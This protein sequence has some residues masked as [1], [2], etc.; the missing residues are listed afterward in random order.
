MD[1]EKK[2]FGNGSGNFDDADFIL[3][4]NQWINMENCRIGS[5][6]NGVIGTVESI[7]KILL[8]SDPEPSITNVEIGSVEDEENRRIIYFLKDLYGPW[9][10]IVVYDLS[11]DIFL[12]VLYTFQVT[13]GLNFNKN[14]LI[15]SARVI[16]GLLYWTDNLNQPRRINIDAGINMN[17]PATIPN[18]EPYTNPLTQE[19]I[20]VIRRPPYYPPSI[21]KDTDVDYVNNFIADSATQ[22]AVRYRY[23]D[24]E[25][26]VIGP[27]SVLAP[28]NDSEDDSNFINITIPT[29]EIIDQ[30]V[31]EAELIVK[32]GNEAMAF[33]IHTWDRDDIDAHN[34]GTALEFDF[35]NDI[36]GSAL[37]QPTVAKPFDSVP[38]L[39]KTLETANNR[40]FLGNNL[41]G[42]NTPAITSLVIGAASV[43]D[44]G[45]YDAVWGIYEMVFIEDGSQVDS[46]AVYVAFISD[47]GEYYFFAEVTT[48]PLPSTKSALDAEFN[49]TDISSIGS[50]LINNGYVTPPPDW[51]SFTDSFDP[52]FG[53]GLPATLTITDLDVP[54]TEGQRSFKSEGSYAGGIV[55]FDKFRRKCGV[56]TAENITVEMPVR[57]YDTAVFNVGMT[58]EVSNINAVNEIPDWAY[59]YAP[60]RTQN[61]QTR[62]FVQAR[63]VQMFYVTRDDD[64]TYDYTNTGY[65]TDRYAIGVDISNLVNN[66]M[67][68]VFAEGDIMKLFFDTNPPNDT[69][70]SII[71]QDGKWLLVQAKDFGTLG[72]SVKPLFEIYTPYIQSVSEPYY[73]VGQIFAVLNPGTVSRTYSV[74]GGILNGDI[75]ILTRGETGSEYFTENMS[76]NDKFWS[77]WYTDIA[78]SNFIDKIGQQLK[79][80]SISWSNIYIQGTKTNGLSTFDALDE[81]PIPLE[82][83]TIQKLQL[84]SKVNNEQGVVMLS[85]CTRETASMYMGEQ[86]LLSTNTNAFVAQSDNVIGTINILKGSFGTINPES[87]TEFRGNVYWVDVLNGKVIQYSLNGLYPISAYKMS[88]YWQLFSLQYLSMSQSQIEALGSRPF[89]FTAVD[90]RHWELLISVPKLLNTP[91]RGYLPD[92]PSRVY[93][94]DIW[95]GQA[96]TLVYKLNIEPNFWQGAY[97]FGNVEGF[98]AIQNRLF[99]F[100][101]GLLFELNSTSD[102]GG[103]LFP[104]IMFVSN[105]VPSRPK[106]YNNISLEVNQL[107]TFTYFMSEQPYQQ[108]SNLQDF[109]WENLEGVLYSQIYR[110]VLTPSATGLVPN[111]L[112]VGEKMRTY[113]LRVMLEFQTIELPLELRFV[114]LGYS[115]SLGHKT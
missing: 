83:G 52:T 26:S 92:Y 57:T 96:K 15:H 66:G 78:W 73:E 55:F 94:F 90:P 95:D 76:P 35:Y 93:P 39:S 59:Y 106:V 97:T 70:V 114:N 72:A 46:F 11:Q 50:F 80:N 99:Q 104:R 8:L 20:T 56:V 7:G 87:V 38:L 27:Y 77:N 28:F 5:T 113:A 10:K 4:P 62:F 23:R 18:V 54:V 109:D 115:I 107:P 110:N 33:I 86:Q 88:R 85:I 91:P 89:I 21:E 22:F 61:L 103:I 36:K 43:S 6:D 51:D 101:N 41:E 111:A 68:Y 14:S 34:T 16:N 24:Y 17:Y 69:S 60:V 47:L 79:E 32:Y 65:N 67:G 13:G 2:Y 84:T 71:G 44:D 3:Q 49:T 82:C 81:K 64:G 100:R 30:D 40:L 12:T 48:P 108:V 9:D 42:Y 19:V 53:T 58:W 37:D 75:Y 29:S 98:I 105:Q 74:V 112:V 63:A 25:Y 102:L 45:E 1:Y 31:I